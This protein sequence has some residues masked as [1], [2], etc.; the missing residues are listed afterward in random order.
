MFS[1]LQNIHSQIDAQCN[2]CENIV[3]IDDVLNGIN[4]VKS[5]KCDGCGLVCTDHFIPAPHKL[6]ELLSLGNGVSR[7]YSDGSN[8]ATIQPLVKKTIENQLIT[9]IIIEPLLLVAPVQTILLGY[10]DEKC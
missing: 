9:L 3:T 5:N 8:I 4:Q 2:D 6:H 7:V 1:L 10:H